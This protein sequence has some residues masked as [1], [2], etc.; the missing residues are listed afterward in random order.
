MAAS[1]NPFSTVW[2][3]NSDTGSVISEP[4]LGDTI[5]A[6]LP[7]WHGPFG[8]KAEA[9]AYYQA[10]AAANP[11]W[12][13]PTGLA[14]NVANEAGDAAGSVLGN[15]FKLVLGNTTG[16]LSRILKVVFGGILLIAGVLKLSGADKKLEAVLPVVGG[17]AGKVLAA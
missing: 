13:A 10:N 16:L 12:K 6:H 11:G 9:L 8:T 17:P 2:F 15:G 4:A 1:T 7:G 3:Y 14:G 5:Q